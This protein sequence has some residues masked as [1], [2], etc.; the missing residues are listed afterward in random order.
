MPRFG[1]L[2]NGMCGLRHKRLSPC[3]SHLWPRLV[4][5]ALSS[6]SSQEQ[7]NT[8]TAPL[9]T[10]HRDTYTILSPT[11]ILGYGFPK[12]SLE[13]AVRRFAP[14]DL[15]AVDAGSIDPGPYY[16]ATGKSFTSSQAVRRDLSLLLPV[17]LEQGCPLVVGSCGG[18]GAGEQLQQVQRIVFQL[19]DELGLS[20]KAKVATIPADVRGELMNEWMTQ[21]KLTS[22]GRMPP[23]QQAKLQ[24]ASW[25]AQMGVD[26]IATALHLGANVVLCG[27]AYDPAVFAADPIRKGFDV[28][29]TLHASKV[30]ECGAIACTP[31]SGADSL[32]AQIHRNGSPDGSAGPCAVFHA[33]SA[34]R[35]VTP[36]TIAAHTLYEKSHPHM[37]H[38]PGGVLLST[39]DSEFFENGPRSAG[40]KATRAL[41]TSTNTLK[42]EGAACV[43]HRVLSVYAVPEGYAVPHLTTPS[44]ESASVEH[45][46]RVYGQDGVEA[47]ALA[48][49]EGEEEL[50]VIFHVEGPDETTVAAV[51]GSLRATALHFGYAGRLA[52][53][54]NLAFPWCPSDLVVPST[55]E[56]DAVPKVTGMVACGS[57]DPV[58]LPQWE[59]V[60]EAVRASVASAMPLLWEQCSVKTITGGTNRGQWLVLLQTV[61]EDPAQALSVHREAVDA[62]IQQLPP[63]VSLLHK[64]KGIPVCL[65]RATPA[66]VATRFVGQH[67]IDCDQSVLDDL[68]PI[69]MH[70]YVPSA[71]N[72]DAVNVAETLG[73]WHAS[74]SYSPIRLPLYAAQHVDEYPGLEAMAKVPEQPKSTG[75]LSD[76]CTV[77]DSRADDMGNKQTLASV[78]QVIRSKNAGINELTFDVTFKRRTHLHTALRLC[79]FAPLAMAQVFGIDVEDVLGCYVHHQSN[80][81]KVTTHR[82]CLAG[83]PTDG[84]VYGAQQHG[85]LLQKIKVDWNRTTG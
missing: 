23:L 28:A 45:S 13:E 59:A 24:D 46:L 12:S 17:A 27:R 39:Y 55:E 31:G 73:Q 78:A 75:L 43:G 6:A 81:I 44:A 79:I 85:A 8:N 11:A 53:A 51:L 19:L 22:L 61:A 72:K 38:L 68:F 82:K 15:I 2:L 5:R 30:L 54:G 62:W 50:G 41:R 65:L 3:R 57:R 71:T 64:D 33:L 66:G 10:H 9:G 36:M 60:D 80:T 37:F 76:H 49:D 47:R 7:G 77:E 20:H 52:T 25:V 34:Q 35:R 83:D 1:S 42:I 58:L 16:L 84:D 48:L 29:T 40:L 63:A 32:V 67:L 18:C 70:T 14:L 21:G 74:T 26:P 69:T 4:R 56:G